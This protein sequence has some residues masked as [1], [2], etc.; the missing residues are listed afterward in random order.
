M[1]H[2]LVTT[3]LPT[4][5]FSLRLPAATATAAKSCLAPT[6]YALKLS[7]VD[8]EIRTAGVNSGMELFDVLKG[9]EVRIELPGRLVVTN[10][11]VRVALPFESK[12]KASERATAVGEAKRQDQYPFR[13][14]VAFREFV[15]FGGP[16][17]VAWTVDGVPAPDQERLLSAWRRL[18]WIGKRGS[19][20]MPF[21]TAVEFGELPRSFSFSVG[22]AVRD[23]PVD[24][25]LQ[26]HDDLGP[27]AQFDRVSTYSVQ[28]VRVGIDRLPV[29]VAFPLRVLRRGRG[30]TAYGRAV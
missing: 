23:F 20:V 8:A 3:L 17:R 28:K 29:F 2:W 7:L 9:C 27:N 21:P 15:H 10:A 5:L 26:A 12:V 1:A 22:Q 25:I 14:S 6:P 16:L 30:F 24:L 18:Q 4:S 11:L 13:P 19:F